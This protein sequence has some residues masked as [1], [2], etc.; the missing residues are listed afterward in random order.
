MISAADVIH[1]FACPALGIECD[2]YP[3]TLN[4]MSVH[5]NREGTFF[6][7]CSEICGKLHC[8]MPISIPS[9]SLEKFLLWLR[10]Q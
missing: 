5:I 7:Q 6:G 10:N 1:S 8:S 4:Q 9:V 2:A 3:G